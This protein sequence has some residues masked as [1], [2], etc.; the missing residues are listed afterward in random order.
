[1]HAEAA[2][3]LRDYYLQRFEATK[4]TST[5]GFGSAMY[6]AGALPAATLQQACSSL[7]AAAGAAAAAVIPVA[8][9]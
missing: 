8:A 1:L 5:C 7:A 6:W 9:M 2:P 4:G 3:P